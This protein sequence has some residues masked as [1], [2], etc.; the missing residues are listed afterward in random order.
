MEQV[1]DI[2]DNLSIVSISIYIIF[3][4]ILLLY[5]L[6]SLLGKVINNLKGGDRTTYLQPKFDDLE[7]IMWE[8]SY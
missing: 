3:I 6:C 1:L 7:V 5:L 4:I 2:V 8:V